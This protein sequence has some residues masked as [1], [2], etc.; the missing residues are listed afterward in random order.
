LA[1]VVAAVSGWRLFSAPRTADRPL[2]LLSVDLG[3]EAVRGSR[4]TAVL[5]PDGRRIVFTGRGPGG[6]RQLFTR[7][8]DQPAATPLAGT[9]S[10][11]SARASQFL[12]FF[13]PDGE[14]IAFF[15]DG[16]VKK[17]AAEG[18]SAI[19]LGR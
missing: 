13:S 6:G 17:V 8:L 4:I 2:M 14:W 16:K 18:G 9:A 11:S 19:T 10:S 5:S 3:P 12:P 15:A 1:S 7:R